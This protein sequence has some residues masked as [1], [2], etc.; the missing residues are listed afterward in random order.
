MGS[1]HT[2]DAAAKRTDEY[3]LQVPVCGGR[4]SSH[5]CIQSDRE[6]LRL[7]LRYLGRKPQLLFLPHRKGINNV[8]GGVTAN[9]SAALTSS[10]HVCLC[11][12][13]GCNCEVTIVENKIQFLF[14]PVETS[15][16]MYTCWVPY[17]YF[18]RLDFSK[19]SNGNGNLWC[20]SKIQA[21]FPS[22]L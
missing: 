13:S 2:P 18:L 22:T 21:F 20:K 11:S 9:R 16:F 1:T 3:W 10:G 8:I 6:C 7:M 17:G 4:C 15:T 12:C 19:Y 5:V 14:L